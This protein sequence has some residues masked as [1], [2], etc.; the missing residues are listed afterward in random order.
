MNFLVHYRKESPME[1]RNLGEEENG[2]ESM[3]LYVNFGPFV[4]RSVLIMKSEETGHG[5]HYS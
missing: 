4:T 1:L 3:E 2:Y 5:S